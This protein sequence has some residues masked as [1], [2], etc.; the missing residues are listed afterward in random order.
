M[1][2]DNS[3]LNIPRSTPDIWWTGTRAA[4]LPCYGLWVTSTWGQGEK[5]R[6]CKRTKKQRRSHLKN[7]NSEIA[8]TDHWVEREVKCTLDPNSSR[9][10]TDAAPAGSHSRH[11]QTLSAFCNVSTIFN[12]SR[13]VF[14]VQ[15][16][17]PDNLN[18][19]FNAL[20]SLIFF[21]LSNCAPFGSSCLSSSPV[22]FNSLGQ[23]PSKWWESKARSSYIFHGE[24]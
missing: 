14:L 17:F 8:H 9:A 16:F 19:S 20:Y 7:G 11:R 2:K 21:V 6:L 22:T 4:D 1:L 12:S 15:V 24:K 23:V 3:G 10:P 5:S 18:F 13:W